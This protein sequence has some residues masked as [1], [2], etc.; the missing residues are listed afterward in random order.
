MPKV[1]ALWEWSLRAA[2]PAVPWLHPD[3][4]R[5]G[6]RHRDARHRDVRRVDAR[7]AL[8]PWLPALQVRPASASQPRAACRGARP[9]RR[10]PVQLP[11]PA[12]AGCARA[13]RRAAAGS[14][15]GVREL[16]PA[17]ASQAWLRVAR[18]ARAPRPAAVLRGVLRAVRAVPELPAAS[19]ARGQPRAAE[20]ERGAL[21]RPR[22]EPAASGAEELPQAAG[23]VGSDAL[24]LR[25]AA[26]RDARVARRRVVAPAGA[27][28]LLAVP[29]VR[30]RPARGV[31][32]A[33]SAFR[34][35]RFLPLA[36]L[37][38]RPAARF[39]RATLKWRTA[40]PSAQSWQ[41]ARDE[42][43]SWSL[44]SPAEKSGQEGNREPNNSAAR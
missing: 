35:V 30:V 7:R 41:A 21:A 38:R 27:A 36:A 2:C 37:V 20:A 42:A 23:A 9:E 13:L 8:V 14:A 43:L 15:W 39:V 18:A 5:P 33:A 19:D 4:R 31:P 17:V 25:P 26:E 3:V 1:G 34:Q 12:S 16:R 44:E 22:A 40:S 29:D 24:A 28:R 10:H 32:A 11:V 6:A